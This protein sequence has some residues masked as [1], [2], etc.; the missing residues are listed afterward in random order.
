MDDSL[1]QSLLTLA[2]ILAAAR[3]LGALAVRLRQ[4]R[5]G[6]EMLAGLLVGGAILSPWRH[7]GLAHHTAVVSTMVVHFIDLLGQVGVILYLL[8]VG[9]TLSPLDLRRNAK[10]VLAVGLPVIVAAAAVAP[11]GAAWFAG[12]R[13]Q[14][15]GGPAAG[16][17]MAAALM[18]NGF[19]FVARIL[20]ERELLGDGFGATVLGA[21]ALLTALPFVLLAAAERRVP[22]NGI[23]S[24]GYALQILVTLA[25]GLG[26]AALWPTLASRFPIAHPRGATPMSLAVISAL[27]VAWLAGK[28]LGSDLLGA[29]LVG[30]ALSRSTRTRA[31]LQS[32]LGRSVPAL[33]VPVFLAAAGAR[34]DPRVLDAGVL[35][36]AALFTALLVVVAAL[37]GYVSA[38]ISHVGASDA[39]A[40]MALINCRG[41]MLVALGIEM[42]DR[43]LV[44][45]RLVAVFFIGAVATTLMTGPLLARAGRLARRAASRDRVQPPSWSTPEIP[46][47]TSDQ[48]PPAAA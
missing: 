6:G 19:P 10:R 3:L 15:A 36:G 20:Q 1:P 23:A 35:E 44:G 11:V 9:L 21:S 34:L 43:R 26:A 47:M 38:R 13:W 2:A 17:V 31:A 48:R 33:F 14:L 7:A 8:L 28:L 22:S 32:A 29:F 37:G 16:L 40:I 42:A 5:I 27:L 12:A 18:I 24:L 25:L 46:A 41:M 4:P 30:I 39:R 45:S